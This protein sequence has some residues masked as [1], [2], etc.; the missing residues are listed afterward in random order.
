MP[1]SPREAPLPPQM[2]GRWTLPD[3]PS[4][5]VRIE[6][7]EVIW[8]GAA[9]NYDYKETEESEGAVAV[10]LCIEDAEGAD[11]FGHASI[12]GLLHTPE[13]QLHVHNLD[14]AEQL[15]RSSD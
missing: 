8:A 5:E 6:G 4:F 15:V 13:G 12:L 9:S 14:F 10:S 7:G 3:D 2:Q 1:R 11:E